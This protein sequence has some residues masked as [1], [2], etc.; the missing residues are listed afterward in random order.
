MEDDA[1]RPLPLQ[2]DVVGVVGGGGGARD[3]RPAAHL[4]GVGNSAKQGGAELWGRVERRNA[5]KVDTHVAVIL[6]TGF[7]ECMYNIIIIVIIT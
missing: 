1:A 5:G 4:L 6:Y 2:P 7:L 3:G